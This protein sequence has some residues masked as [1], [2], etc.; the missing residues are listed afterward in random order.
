MGWSGPTRIPSGGND[1]SAGLVSC[2]C[3]GQLDRRDGLFVDCVGTAAQKRAVFITKSL[4]LP[5]YGPTIPCGSLERNPC[6]AVYG[7]SVTASPW[8]VDGG[9]IGMADGPDSQAGT[10]GHPFA[11]NPGSRSCHRAPRRTDCAPSLDKQ[12]HDRS[13]PGSRGSLV[14]SPLAHS[15]TGRFIRRSHVCS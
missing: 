8:N 6:A 9:S 5:D 4:V 11:C 7:P 10:C 15:C 1:G 2:T 14:R 12:N 3:S 13:C